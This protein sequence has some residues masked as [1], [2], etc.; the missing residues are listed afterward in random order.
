MTNFRRRNAISA[1]STSNEALALVAFSRFL[2]T[3]HRHRHH[4]RARGSRLAFQQDSQL[5]LSLGAI[6]DTETQTQGP[7]EGHL[8]IVQ[9][10]F[11]PA[12]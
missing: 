11:A 8:E 10:H 2:Q 7:Q 1:Y 6:T 12:A 5:L 4:P 9:S 3:C